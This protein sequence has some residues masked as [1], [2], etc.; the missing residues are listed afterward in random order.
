MGDSSCWVD[1]A[2]KQAALG[3]L[4]RAVPITRLPSELFQLISRSGLAEFVQLSLLFLPFPKTWNQKRVCLT[5]SFGFAAC[6]IC[7][8]LFIVVK[9]IMYF[10]M[11]WPMSVAR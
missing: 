3:K 8:S 5:R 9:R 2:Q 11:A 10:D 4:S 1:W 7:K 6:G